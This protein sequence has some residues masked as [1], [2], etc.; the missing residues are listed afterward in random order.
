MK[1]EILEDLFAARRVRDFGMKLEAV[2]FALRIFDRGERRILRVRGARENLRGSA[3]TLSPWLF[4]ISICSPIPS[5]SC[6]PFETCEH[7]RRRIRAGA[8]NSTWPPR[9]CAI[10]CIP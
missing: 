5:K 9:W 3:V 7:A 1:D 4:Q 10:S 2:E 8:L 6:E